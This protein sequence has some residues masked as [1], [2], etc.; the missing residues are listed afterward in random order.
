MGEILIL[1]KIVNELT[2]NNQEYILFGEKDYVKI[3]GDS[4]DLVFHYLLRN[5][6]F[7]SLHED[8]L[9]VVPVLGYENPDDYDKAI[10]AINEIYLKNPNLSVFA[11]RDAKE[12]EF[13]HRKKTKKL[14]GKS[15]KFFD[16]NHAGLGTEVVSRAGYAITSEEELSNKFKDWTEDNKRFSALK[17]E[18]DDRYLA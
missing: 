11:I 7:E 14:S 8:S 12:K 2:G 4:H 17:K 18:L 15:L 16:I 6:P 3:G 1:D 13:T 5:I 9:L 10:I